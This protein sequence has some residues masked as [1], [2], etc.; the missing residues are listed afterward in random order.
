MLPKASKVG[1][2]RPESAMPHVATVFTNAKPEEGINL[3]TAKELVRKGH[4]CRFFDNVPML[5]Y[6]LI[7]Y[8]EYIGGI[9]AQT[10]ATYII[11]YESLTKEMTGKDKR[12]GEFLELRKQMAVLHKKVSDNLLGIVGQKSVDMIVDANR[13]EITIKMDRNLSDVS[14]DELLQMTHTLLHN[15]NDPSVVSIKT[16]NNTKEKK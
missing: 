1:S 12:W 4:R 6:E 15:V 2:E 3:A 8:N 9:R 11:P 14:Q 10:Q 5:R 13:G 7:I 16:V